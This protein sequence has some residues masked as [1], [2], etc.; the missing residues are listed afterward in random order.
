MIGSIIVSNKN[1]GLDRFETNNY[2]YGIDSLNHLKS[3]NKTN[4]PLAII[5]SC[6]PF[7]T[8]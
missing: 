4:M 6:L 5:C 8:F 1:I 3:L 2:P 7:C